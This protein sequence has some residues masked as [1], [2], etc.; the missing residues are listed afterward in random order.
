MKLRWR[1]VLPFGHLTVDC[2]VLVLWLWHAHSLYRP[3]ADLI[4]SRIEPVLLLQ[5]R[6]SVAFDP[7]FIS[8]SAEFLL[9]ASGTLPAML[10]SG[11]VRPEAHIPTPKKLWDPVWFLIHEIVSFLLWFAVG[12]ALESGLLRIRKLMAA[13]LAVRF[14]FAALLMVHGVADIG[15]RIE[16]LSWL[17]FG[18]YAI[19]VFLR[20]VFSKI[21]LS[22]ATVDS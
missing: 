12:V 18:V 6:G 15:W 14:G 1:I 4:P 21:H 3:K 10:V 13:Y 2:V 16:V 7:K 17:A 20:W 19:V 5:E 9:L 8:P 11:T 22:R